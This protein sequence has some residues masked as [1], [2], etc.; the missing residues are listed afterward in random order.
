[1]NC[2][3]NRLFHANVLGKCH[4]NS[5]FFKVILDDKKYKLSNFI[6]QKPLVENIKTPAELKLSRG[7]FINN[8]IMELAD[9]KLYI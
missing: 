3:H 9:L 4:C 1:M 2:D 5:R 6:P 7:L 8:Y